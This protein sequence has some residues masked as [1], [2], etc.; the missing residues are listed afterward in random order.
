M[1]SIVLRFS[2]LLADTK[3]YISIVFQRIGGKALT[4]V[5]GDSHALFLCGAHSESSRKI[6]PTKFSGV[7]VVWLG[8]RL[9]NSIG[10][11]GFPFWVRLL[12]SSVFSKLFGKLKIRVDV[13]LGEIDIRCH[14][15]PHVA[16]NGLKEIDNLVDRFVASLKASVG[17]DGVRQLLFYQP[18]PPSD[19]CRESH[20]FPRAGE[21]AERIVCH[22][23]LS[24]YIQQR[25][26][27]LALSGYPFCFVA[28]P[29]EATLADG[30]LNPLW[31]SDGCHFNRPV[32][33]VDD[34]VC[35]AES[36]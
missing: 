18:V 24:G 21:L 32:Y 9:M 3:C 20:E 27:E 13:V 26:F 29:S 7:Y 22:R 2:D 5:I 1:S 36:F 35:A 31:S 11:H 16:K 6:R 25:F 8:P 28:S 14:L 34:P 23:Y 30:S 12:I 33:L 4:L 19:L 15:V 17:I 10:N